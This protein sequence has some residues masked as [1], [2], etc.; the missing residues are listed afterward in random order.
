[1]RISRLILEIGGFLK[2][3]MANKKN[4]I[5]LRD[6]NLSLS[7]GLREYY[8][9]FQDFW[10]DYDDYHDYYCDC[11]ICVPDYKY[12]PDTESNLIYRSWVGRRLVVFSGEP[13]LGKMIDMRT[14]YSKEVLREKKIDAILGLSDDFNKITFADIW[15]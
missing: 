15:K 8:E 6:N 2:L 5:E 4:K 1:M 3:S 10:Y 12:L 14:I 9:W 7:E 11:H 13:K